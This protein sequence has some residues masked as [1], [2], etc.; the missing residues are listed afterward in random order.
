MNNKL[1]SIE[2]LSNE[3]VNIENQL[4]MYKELEKKDKELKQK[5]YEAMTQN[6]IKKWET[7]NGTKVTLVNGTDDKMEWAFNE[8]KFKE[9]QPLMYA[10]YCREVCKPGRSGYVRITTGG[11]DND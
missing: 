7:P 6:N 9:D 5:L 10:E 8:S 2:E 4:A 1:M 3:I 11:V